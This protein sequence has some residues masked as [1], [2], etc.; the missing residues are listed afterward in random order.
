M[1]FHLT[2]RMCASRNNATVRWHHGVGEG[3][4]GHVNGGGPPAPPTSLLQRLGLS[5]L[6]KK[7]PR[8]IIPPG[9]ARTEV[10]FCAWGSG[11]GRDDV[12]NQNL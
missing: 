3:E 10:V 5:S 8:D 2:G 6:L 4:G 1:N 9:E 7:W 12:E 11:R